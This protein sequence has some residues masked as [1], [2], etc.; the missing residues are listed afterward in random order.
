MRERAGQIGGRL[1]IQSAPGNG[2]EVQV[3]VA[4]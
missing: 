3:E 1:M 4:R 2:T